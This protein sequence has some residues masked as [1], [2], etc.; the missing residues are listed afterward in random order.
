[1]ASIQ[2]HEGRQGRSYKITV[3]CGVDSGG[4]KIRH[5]L[6]WKPDAPMTARQEMK[7]V[8]RIAA[9]FERGLDDGFVL[10]NGKLFYDYAMYFI[11]LQEMGGIAAS[12]LARYRYANERFKDR[13]G[14][15]KLTD[16]K[17]QHLTKLY[18]DLM[19]DGARQGGMTAVPVADFAAIVKKRGGWHRFVPDH[20]T[21]TKVVSRLI[22]HKPIQERTAH[23]I[24]D[25]LKMPYTEL[26]KDIPPTGKLSTR[27]IA[28]F[29][30]FFAAVLRQAEKEMLIRY[31]PAARATVPK[32]EYKQMDFLTPEQLQEVLAAAD[33]EPPEMRVKLY[34]IATTGMRRGELL[35]LTWDRIDLDRRRITVDRTLSCTKETGVIMGQTKT[36]KSRIV[37]IP[38]ALVPMLR[39]YRREW[40]AHKLA[41]GDL[42]ANTEVLFPSDDGKLPRPTR[43]NHDLDLF[44]KRHGLPHL[45]PHTFRH[46]VASIMIA[47]GVDVVT[48]SN[49]LGHSKPSMTTNV[50][51]HMIDEAQH[52]AAATIAD[53]L[54]LAKAE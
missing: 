12:T 49:V 16:I 48:V 10:D 20:R 8:R 51:A 11:D 30:S 15:M 44:T 43:L 34:L 38:S 9:E 45:H 6:T 32:Q 33:A 7:E 31:N 29:H 2:K 50:Y 37:D 19:Q 52:R 5:Y 42:W 47:S 40:S 36:R 53:A 13:I 3:T 22:A 24:A 27:T 18:R 17:P 26:F 14:C 46:S 28:I 21:S 54:N 1:M 4:K 23:R 35:A 41:M 39:K 25:A